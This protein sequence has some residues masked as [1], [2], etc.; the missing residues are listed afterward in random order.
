MLKLNFTEIYNE[1]KDLV[2]NLALHYSLNR[3][4]AEEIV[5]DVFLKVHEKMDDFRSES[6]LKTWIYRITV[7]HSLDFL[8]A[9][10]RK[11]RL[12][13]TTALRLS[14]VLNPN[15]L[16]NFDHP[17]VLMEQREE[18]ERLL[19]AINRL[20]HAQKTAIIL[21]KMEGL[22]Q[23]ETAKV[24]KTSIKSVESLFQR[25]KRKLKEI[26]DTPKEKVHLIVKELHG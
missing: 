26:L 7:N 23:V 20:P 6:S 25:G 13:N 15:F 2:F 18:L 22:S 21:L 14:E 1:H 16:S 4:D 17:G 10:K 8:K 9:K 3:L 24:M 19:R 5:Q 11:K 12:T